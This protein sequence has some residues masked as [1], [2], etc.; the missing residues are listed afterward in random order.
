M[1]LV[2]RSR[3]QLEEIDRPSIR[4]ANLVVRPPNSVISLV[5]TQFRHSR[6]QIGADTNAL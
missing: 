1:E 3:Q 6:H 5:M 2:R 4:G